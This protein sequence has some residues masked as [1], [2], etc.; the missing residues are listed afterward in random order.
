MPGEISCPASPAPPTPYCVG[1]TAPTTTMARMERV[2][3]F[4]QSRGIK[5]VELYGYPG[6]PFPSATAGRTRQPAG[7]R[8][9]CGR[10][11]TSTGSGSRAA[12]ASLNEARW[13]TEIAVSRILGQ[14]HIGE[15]GPGGAGGVGSYAG[16][17]QTTASSSTSSASARSSW[18]SGPAY[19]HNHAAEFSRATPTAVHGQ[20]RAQERVGDHDGAHRPALGRRAD[21]HRLGGVRSAP[22]RRPSTRPSAWRTCSAMINKFSRARD[23]SFHV[24]DMAATASAR[25]AATPSSAS[26]ARARSTSR[27]CSRPRRTR[28]STT[29][30][31]VTRSRSAGR[32][33]ST[34]STTPTNSAE[35]DQA[36]PG[37]RR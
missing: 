34:R 37:A 33:T 20:R 31:S 12:T 3:A 9:S 21:R 36:R 27:R 28:R 18:A 32:R 7:L 30:P 13:D 29:S 14:D 8:W 11:V 15:S 5:N 2:F 17:L 1:P 35:R 10:S 26:S 16:R 23:L 19:F 6:N 25:T 22:A 4:L 24:K